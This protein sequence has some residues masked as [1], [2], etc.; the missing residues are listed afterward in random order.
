[1]EFKAVDRRLHGK[2]VL[3]QARLAQM[4]LLDVFAEICEKYGLRYFLS[5]GT[6]IGAM[7]H[8]GYIPWDDDI[9]VGMPID[10]YKRFIRLAP[11]VLPSNLL[12]DHS[13][14]IVGTAGCYAK[15][16]DRSSFFCER[17]SMIEVPCGIF[18]DI[19]P[20][21][22]LPVL[23][24]KVFD[25]IWRWCALSAW[26]YRAYLRMLHRNTFCILRSALMSVFWNLAHLFLRGIILSLKMLGRNRWKNAPENDINQMVHGVSDADLFPTKPHAFEDR[27][28]QVPNN[29]D[30]FLTEKFGDW[31]KLPP[32]KDRVWHADI[33]C[34]TKA[35]RAWWAMPYK[36]NAE[37][38]GGDVA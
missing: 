9:D 3:E 36:S 26:S 19:F 4:Y 22:K 11:D 30:L 2:S 33:I 5:D 27:Q 16:R 15:I 6:L 24:G 8:A 21:E 23:P 29:A 37:N 7:R 12:L 18:I 25:A 38:L 1:M 14:Q 10:D 13:S 34:P 31:R 32:E 17:N 20:Y 35:P 28:Y